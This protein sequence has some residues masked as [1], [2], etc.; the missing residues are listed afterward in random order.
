MSIKIIDND[1]INASI[2]VSMEDM[3]KSQI[4]VVISDEWEGTFVLRTNSEAIEI[5]DLSNGDS[6]VFEEGDVS[7]NEIMVRLL[8]NNE[9][10]TIE[11]SND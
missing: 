2:I 3:N 1:V 6:W 7:L 10:I 9:K 11:L 8:N 4:G 5:L